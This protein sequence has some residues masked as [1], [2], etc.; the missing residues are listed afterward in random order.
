MAL[1]IVIKKRFYN[2]LRKLSIYLDDEWGINYTDQYLST[3]YRKIQL[4]SLNPQLGIETAIKKTRSILAGKQNRIY[5]R[6]EKN[7]V[8][9][10][11]IYDTRRNPAKNPFN[12]KQ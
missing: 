5:Y 3:V 11:N 6:V 7:R 8:I 4:L 12:K 2:S 10:L 1:E 9:I